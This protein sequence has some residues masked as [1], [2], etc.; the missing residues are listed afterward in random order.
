MIY[1]VWTSVVLVVVN[2]CVSV[3][4]LIGAGEIEISEGVV[5][6]LYSKSDA[7]V[8]TGTSIS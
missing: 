2:V 1:C 6:S 8:V 7:S 4:N 5:C 3:V